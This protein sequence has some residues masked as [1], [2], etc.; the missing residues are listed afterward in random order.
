MIPIQKNNPW[1]N[2]EDK[3]ETNW[4]LGI[5]CVIF[6]GMFVNITNIFAVGGLVNLIAF[7]AGCWFGKVVLNT[8]NKRVKKPSL[9]RICKVAVLLIVISVS[10]SA[11]VLMKTANRA[12]DA[13]FTGIVSEQQTEEI[14]TQIKNLST[15]ELRQFIEEAMDLKQKELP[16]KIDSRTTFISSGVLDKTIVWKY[17][18]NMDPEDQKLFASS[19]GVL[20]NIVAF[21]CPDRFAKAVLPRG[22]IINIVYLDTTGREIRKFEITRDA[23]DKNGA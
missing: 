12:S 13:N 2:K 21:A 10:V 8:L 17:M 5:V 19:E 7:A 14:E 16:K 22:Y 20:K 9:N 23:C 3:K 6:G 4:K 15:Y 11:T 18:I 1:I